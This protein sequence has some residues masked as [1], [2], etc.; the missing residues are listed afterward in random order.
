MASA[1]INSFIKK[2]LEL[3]KTGKDATFSLKTH[4]GEASVSLHLELGSYNADE[5]K[6]QPYHSKKVI[7]SQVSRRHRRAQARRAA[8]NN[9][10][11]ETSAEDVSSSLIQTE[12]VCDK[13]ISVEEVTS[14][15]LNT[16]EA[17]DMQMDS[18]G[19]EEANNV[20][21]IESLDEEEP[22]E[23]LEDDLSLELE[24][25]IKQSQKNRH[26]WEKGRGLT[27]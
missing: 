8:N 23:V 4:A 10:A 22:E 24:H 12:N 17:N 7:P 1:E 5:V 14:H 9:D 26:L 27:S 15:N 13:E 3:W 20:D 11:M 16:K 6:E 19:A 18:H 21:E 25:I 2:F